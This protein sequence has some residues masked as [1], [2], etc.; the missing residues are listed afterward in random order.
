MSAWPAAPKFHE[1]RSSGVS[2]PCGVK[3]P[4]GEA[5]ALRFV[6]TRI[7]YWGVDSQERVVLGRPISVGKAK[8]SQAPHNQ[9]FDGVCVSPK[10]RTAFM[11]PGLSDWCVADW[12]LPP[13]IG[14]VGAVWTAARDEF[15][16]AAGTMAYVNKER[17][18]VA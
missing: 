12:H 1:K 8:G 17:T 14:E 6:L 16:S 7:S 9:P 3:L 18:E 13:L 2:S 10:S 4:P 5:L 11:N 15:M